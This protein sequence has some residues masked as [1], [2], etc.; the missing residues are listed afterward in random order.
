MSPILLEHLPRLI[1]AAARFIERLEE[2]PSVWGVSAAFLAIEEQLEE[3]LVNWSGVVGRVI[4]STRTWTGNRA[5]SEDDHVSS[6]TSGNI[7]SLWSRRRPATTGSLPPQQLRLNRATTSPDDTKSIHATSRRKLAEQ[8][9]AIMPTQR[10]LRAAA[11]YVCG[12]LIA[13]SSRACFARRDSYRPPL[14]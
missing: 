10:T 7:S 2:D 3:A 4:S 9:V 1:K 6:P 14:R 5:V 12:L 13:P 11:S 8:N